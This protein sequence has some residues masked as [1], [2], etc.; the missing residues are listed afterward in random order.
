MRTDMAGKVALV[1]GSARGIGKAIAD[2]FAQNG[3]KV[4]YSDL[5]AE[6]AAQAAA[7]APGGRGA[8]V[9]FNVA[10]DQQAGQAISKIIGDFGKLDVLV[11]NAGINS[12]E[13][14]VTIEN[15][16]P[17][18]WD[19]IL[20]V[21]LTGVYLVSRHAAKPML[22]QKSGRIIN[23]AS[24]AGM[25]PLRLQTAYVAAKAGVINLTRS[26]ALEL[27]NRGILVNCICPGSTLTRGTEKLF[28]GDDGVF[29]ESVQQMLAHVPVG[30]PGKPEEIAQGALFFADP[31]NTY[32]NGAVLPVDGGWTAGYT[33]EF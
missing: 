17:D 28:Y 15:Y 1:T 6:V 29:R 19:R 13:H 26:M 9:S 7:E 22:D 31:D 33:R 32:C 24:I 23:I 8:A 16:P 18:L 4:I 30:R 5:D 27:G 3:A 20:R 10:D 2:A 14:R 21:D 25:V 11:N 12:L